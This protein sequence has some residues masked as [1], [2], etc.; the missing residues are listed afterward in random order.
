MSQSSKMYF[1]IA[2]LT[3]KLVSDIHFE[4]INLSKRIL[5][6]SVPDG[7][8]KEDLTIRLKEK[9]E[10]PSPLGDL[11]YD[12][13]DIWKMYRYKDTYNAAI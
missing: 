4:K 12:P 1:E 13:G 5:S 9:F 3:I 6:F 10:E 2:G 7:N 11:I 8:L